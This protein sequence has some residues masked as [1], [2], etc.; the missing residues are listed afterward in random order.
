[1]GAA[2]LL[3]FTP[4]VLIRLFARPYVAGDSLERGLAVAHELH[5]SAG[6]VTTLDL[7]AEEVSGEERVRANRETYL[8]M[9]RAVASDRRFAGVRERPTLSLK[10]SSFTTAP[11]DAGGDGRGS[12]EI[13]RELA[14]EA[15]RLG[16][17]LTVDMEDHAWTDFTLEAAIALHREGFDVGTVLQTRLHRTA[18]DL[19]RIPAGMRVR[20]VIGIY[21]EPPEFALT[22]KEPMKERLLQQAAALLDRGV[23]VEFAT[24]DERCMR[25]FFTECRARALGG[26]ALRGADA[27]R[28]ASRAPARGDRGGAAVAAR[29]RR[30]PGAAVCP[31]RDGVGPG[32]GLLPA[33]SAQQ[34][35][36]DEICSDQSAPVIARPQPRDRPVP[37]GR[38][39][40]PPRGGGLSHSL[41]APR[42]PDSFPPRSPVR[43][44]VT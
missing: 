32:D 22:D 8:E 5:D 7:L 3:E 38:D 25:R 4:D 31:V 27:L 29:A 18:S 14:V 33:A 28:R 41:I 2:R 19:A 26:R 20:L 43:H 12:R 6:I 10:L 30:A 35:Q 34:S 17:P 39:R 37:R 15:K 40:A 21:L 24:H 44:G 11:L 1:L 16:V 42:G 23:Y 13:V 36:Y 9:I